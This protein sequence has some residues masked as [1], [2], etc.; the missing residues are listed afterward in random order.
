MNQRGRE[1]TLNGQHRDVQS[2]GDGSWDSRGNGESGW[3][4]RGS[5][6]RQFLEKNDR[7]DVR[8]RNFVCDSLRME[9]MKVLF[10][11]AATF[12]RLSLSG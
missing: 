6:S 8:E 12:H 5:D 4:R 1:R 3:D 11:R 9:E 2:G 10:C 7:L